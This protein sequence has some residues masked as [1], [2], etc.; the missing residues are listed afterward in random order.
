VSRAPGKI[1]GVALGK[2]LYFSLRHPILLAE[3]RNPPHGRGQP[4]GKF[5][6]KIPRQVKTCCFSHRIEAKKKDLLGP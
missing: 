4:K 1:E 3:L 5:P 2:K 6:V